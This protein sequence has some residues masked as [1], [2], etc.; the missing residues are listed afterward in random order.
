MTGHPQA[1]GA[2]SREEG[3]PRVGGI[4]RFMLLTGHPRQQPGPSSQEEGIPTL[5]G[6]RC[7]T[8][9]PRQRPGAF[10]GE[11]GIPEFGGIRF[12]I[13]HPRQQP[14]ASSQEEGIP[15][16]GGIRFMKARARR[17]LSRRG[18][19]VHDRA[20][21]ATARGI[22]SRRGHPHSWGHPVHSRASQAT[23]GEER[24][25]FMTGIPGN[26]PGHPLK[27]R[28]SPQFVGIWCIKGGFEAT[29]PAILSRRGH[30]HFMIRDE[31]L[32]LHGYLARTGCG[33]HMNHMPTPT[34]ILTPIVYVTP[35]V[36]TN[37]VFN[38]LEATR[39][40]IYMATY[41]TSQTYGYRG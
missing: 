22:L 1:S 28:A 14:G 21:L 12:I 11:E 41:P 15:T 7:M 27:K 40:R 33:D 32:P 18:H 39:A 6:I 35:N 31:P 30:D 19:P 25:R 36:T 34:P 13:G 23:S 29:P 37:I 17:I 24:I 9:H 3:I 26:R 5:G 16:L 4:I 10:C 20:S 2:S 8:G 38:M